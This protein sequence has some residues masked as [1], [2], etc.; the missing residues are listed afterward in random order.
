MTPTQHTI[1]SLVLSTACGMAFAFA[2]I[3]GFPL[4]IFVLP[5]VLLFGALVGLFL[6]PAAIFALADRET[7]PSFAWVVVPTC[8]VSFIASIARG[9]FFAVLATAVVYAALAG[10]VSVVAGRR[11]SRLRWHE[12]GLCG[13]CGYDVRGLKGQTCP[14]CGGNTTIRPRWR[15]PIAV[16]RPE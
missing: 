7:R 1:G 11:R 14:E 2:A 13:Y 12:A 8:T 15:V 4:A 16:L 9:P 10:A 3:P 6:S 5:F